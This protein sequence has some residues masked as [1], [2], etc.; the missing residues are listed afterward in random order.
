MP[1]R[2][3]TLKFHAKRL[4][5]FGLAALFASVPWGCGSIGQIRA[6]PLYAN[7]EQPR[8]PQTLARLEGPIA[9]VDGREVAS[10][11]TAFELLPGCHVVTLQRKIGQGSDNAAWSADLGPIVYAFG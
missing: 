10:K 9:T 11:G 3:F 8:Q 6:Y 1:T 5:S 2:S 7:P 4:T